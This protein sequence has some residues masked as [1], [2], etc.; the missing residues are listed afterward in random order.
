MRQPST[1]TQTAATLA[2]TLTLCGCPTE[3]TDTLNRTPCGATLSFEDTANG[4]AIVADW[5]DHD[6]GTAFLTVILAETEDLCAVGDCSDTDWYE[7]DLYPVTLSADP[8]EMPFQP[9]EGHGYRASFATACNTDQTTTWLAPYTTPLSDP[10]VLLGTTYAS[11]GDTFALIQDFGDHTQMITDVVHM[12]WLP[13]LTVTEARND[14]MTLA[15]IW[16]D[17]NLPEAPTQKVCTSTTELTATFDNPS[18]AT[19]RE[20]LTVIT[21]MGST[22]VYDAVIVGSF[23]ANGDTLGAIAFNG[24]FDLRDLEAELALPVDD[25]CAALAE[26]ELPSCS[27]CPDGELACLQMGAHAV[28]APAES[29]E[30]SLSDD[31]CGIEGNL[32]RWDNHS[33]LIHTVEPE[34]S[35][36]RAVDFEGL[37]IWSVDLPDVIAEMR[38]D[39]TDDSMPLLAISEG[40][41]F[42]ILDR[43]TGEIL[44]SDELEWIA[45]PV[46]MGDIVSA[47]FGGGWGGSGPVP[48][49]GIAGL[50]GPCSIAALGAGA[51]PVW[52]LLAPLL[53][54]FG[55]SRRR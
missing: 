30:F 26:P 49:I 43:E 46:E 1:A 13:M 29:V 23:S 53:G 11:R 48:G 3:W 24:L 52:I 54:L 42:W 40:D 16:P 47:S 50:F 55:R 12:V 51:V 15:M 20:D 8:I 34:S 31:P 14:E 25:L 5:A 33:Q 4:A 32:S 21:G 37:E 45:P 9:R 28:V 22:R 35:M 7:A 27:A 39:F 38:Y 36:V 41:L 19:D 44:G 17:P 2:L 6:S 10:E 18:L